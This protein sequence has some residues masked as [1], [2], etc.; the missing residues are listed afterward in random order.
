MS[1]EIGAKF[2][3]KKLFLDNASLENIKIFFKNKGKHIPDSNIKQA[4]FPENSIILKN[5]NGTAPGCIIQEN[6]KILIMLPGPPNEV[7]PMFENY[8][9]P[10]LKNFQT[11]SLYSKNLNLAGIGESEAS[12]KVRDLMLKSKNP[13]IAPYAK[14]NEVRFRLTSSGKTIEDAKN[15]ITPVIDKMYSIFNNYIYGEDYET[16]PE[17]IVK[18]LINKNLTL[19]TA[20]SCTGGLLS[21][22]LVDI[23]DVS[24]TFLGGVITYSNESKIKELNIPKSL[25]Y[26]KGA[27]SKEVAA[28]MAKNVRIKFNTDIGLSITGIAGPKNENSNKPVGLVY[29]GIAKDENTFVYKLNLAGNREKIRTK[30]VTEILNALRLLILEK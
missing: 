20:E 3:S 30:S 21:S 9:K 6:N 28:A 13:T 8:V 26:E 15:K 23:P 5:D 10:F 12:E 19:S 24:R 1:K 14:T 7:T 29:I 2:F 18:K 11:K 16:L 27:V 17:V 4:Y 22:T 25:L